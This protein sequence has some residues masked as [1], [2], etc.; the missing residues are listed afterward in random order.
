MDDGAWPVFVSLECHVGLDG[1]EE[2]VAIMKEEWGRR[3]VDRA[4]EG[5]EEDRVTPRALRGKIVLMVSVF[6]DFEH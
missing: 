4:V 3:L 6:V 5:V 1:Q 2:L